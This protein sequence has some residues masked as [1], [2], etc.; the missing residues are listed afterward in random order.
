MEYRAIEAKLRELNEAENRAD[1]AFCESR[2]LG[3]ESIADVEDGGDFDR[4]IKEFLEL[5][6]VLKIEKQISA[7][8]KEKRIVGDDLIKKALSILPA[9][10]AGQL[11]EMLHLVSAYEK[12]ID[13][14]LEYTAV[15]NKRPRVRKA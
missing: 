5:P 10:L 12:V 9:K 3:V 13:I 11:G 1:R 7:L 6:E 14:Y 4:L 15:V 2:G 8:C